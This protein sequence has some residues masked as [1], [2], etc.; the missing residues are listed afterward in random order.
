[1]YKKN[2]NQRKTWTELEVTM[3]SNLN[4]PG[5]ERQVLN[6]LNHMWDVKKLIS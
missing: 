3:L 4:K 6:N 2:V 1:M 5:T